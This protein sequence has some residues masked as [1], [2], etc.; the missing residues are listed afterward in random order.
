MCLRV[1]NCCHKNE[2]NFPVALIYVIVSS[3]V[4]RRVFIPPQRENIL[5]LDLLVA[6]IKLCNLSVLNGYKILS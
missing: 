2:Q 3:L 6:K 5:V 1:E 4:A